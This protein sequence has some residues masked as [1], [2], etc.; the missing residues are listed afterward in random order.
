MSK[1]FYIIKADGN[2]Y[3]DE[4]DEMTVNPQSVMPPTFRMSWMWALDWLHTNPGHWLMVPI[5]S[6]VDTELYI[7]EKNSIR[8]SIWRTAK[9]NDMDVESLEWR[10]AM[11]FRVLP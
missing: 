4:S 2:H 5:E 8:S 10:K 6:P 9:R 3:P 7:R 1:P 11:W